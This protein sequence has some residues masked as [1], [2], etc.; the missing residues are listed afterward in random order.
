VKE[1]G[2]ESEEGVKGREGMKRTDDRLVM[3][4]EAGKGR[5]LVEERGITGGG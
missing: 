2:N 5:G 4:G 3:R 1:I